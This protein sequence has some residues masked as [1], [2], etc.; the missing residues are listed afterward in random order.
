MINH[1]NRVCSCYHSRPHYCDSILQH[2]AGQAES[3]EI[4][5]TIS[6][7]EWI[8]YPVPATFIGTLVE[9]QTTENGK[10]T[11]SADGKFENG[12]LIEGEVTPC[13]DS[14]RRMIEV[15]HI[16]VAGE[17]RRRSYLGPGGRGRAH[18]GSDGY[19]LAWR[20]PKPTFTSTPRMETC[21]LAAEG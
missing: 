17:S 3:T 20:I 5:T 21:Q 11:V 4:I 13:G 16:K 10:I 18:T 8:E 12:H 7:K 9:T 15:T 1:K 6:L 2:P 14:F 19:D